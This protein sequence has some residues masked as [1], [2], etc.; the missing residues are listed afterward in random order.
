MR[1]F[2]PNKKYKTIALYVG[3]TCAIAILG[4]L[5]ILRFDLVSS[6]FRALFNMLSP[7]L[8]GLIFAYFCFPIQR[9]YENKAFRKFRLNRLNAALDILNGPEGYD[10]TAI[11]AARRTVHRCRTQRRLLSIFCTY[12]SFLIVL[13]AFAFLVVPQI[14]AEYS[15]F[16][17]KISDYAAVAFNRLEDIFRRF[18]GNIDSETIASAIRALLSA[19]L[20]GAASVVSEIVKIPYSFIFGLIISYY[21]LLR[22]ERFLRRTKRFFAAIIPRK[23]L[24]KVTEVTRYANRTFGRYLIG[25]VFEALI[26]GA[27]FLIVLAIFRF[28]YFALIGL[29][30]MFTN[31]I[32]VFGVYI[33]CIPCALLLCIENPWQAF[34]FLLITFVIT[35]LDGA[36]IGP[37]ILG[38]AL[39]INGVWI[40]ISIT[41]AGAL[42]GVPGMLIGAPVF[43]VLFSVI[44]TWINRRLVAKGLSVD[45]SEYEQMFSTDISIPTR[46]TRR[47]L[48]KLRKKHG[49]ES[50]FAT[51]RE[52]DKE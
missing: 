1:F 44:R 51:K 6:F 28:P 32:P 42:F 16:S 22:K 11:I 13:T 18:G 46:R 27:L 25:K 30:M 2:K 48:S 43:S 41:A 12:L 52:E 4:I 29:V 37:K 40:I 8:F 7:V 45:S 38:N 21:V 15:Q 5:L 17:A 10:E 9:F 33:G 23:R 19:I 31:L 49:S 3:A 24:A 26:I 39:G 14:T 20:S 35:Q 47:I 36:V 34:W 50:A